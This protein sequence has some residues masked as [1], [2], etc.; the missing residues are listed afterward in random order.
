MA[1]RTGPGPQGLRGV[2]KESKSVPTK[3]TVKAGQENIR[4]YAD[5]GHN[6]YLYQFQSGGVPESVRHGVPA[7]PAPGAPPPPAPD[8]WADPRAFQ[9]YLNDHGASP[10][11]KV[12]GIIGPKTLEAARKQ[13]VV[14]PPKPAPQAAPPA[15]PP[16]PAAAP[17]A[18]GGGAAVAADI[19]PLPRATVDEIRARYGYLGA[20]LDQ[21]DIAE[22]IASYD[23]TTESDDQL[24]ARLKGTPTFQNHSTNELNWI[25]LK[26]ADQRAR[27]DQQ[28]TDLAHDAQVLGITI[29][30]DRL[31]QIATDSLRFGWDDTKRSQA[32]AAEFHYQPGQQTGALGAAEVSLKKYAN[33]YL[34]PVADSTLAN[35]ETQIA[36]GTATTDTF[37]QYFIDQAAGLYKGIEKQLRGGATVQQLAEPYK[38]DAATELGINPDSIDFSQ[39][40]WLRA[41]SST[42]PT[43]GQPTMMGRADWLHT[44]RTDPT[45]GWDRSENGV[46]AGYAV[47]NAL[48]QALGLRR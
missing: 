8:P 10:K 32:I 19:T 3:Q 11:L 40:K 7:S 31:E 2:A 47:G 25:A 22:V 48:T 9:Q 26:P 28:K 12:D 13:N 36:E 1:K 35:W 30:P 16:P 45:Y 37:K 34:V 21:P 33:D 4:A 27:I 15:A 41:L 29:A 17:V 18:S 24:L 44:L 14:V 5:Q 6:A 23:S 20:L 46:A 38:Q 39:P 43:T 42:D